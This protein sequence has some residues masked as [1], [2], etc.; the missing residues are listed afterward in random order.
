MSRKWLARRL[1]LESL[2][3][4]HRNVS[5]PLLVATVDG[6]EAV[7]D[8]HGLRRAG[9]DAEE[10]AVGEPAAEGALCQ[11]DLPEAASGRDR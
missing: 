5:C 2:H 11:H 3:Q 1:P 9:F 7:L 6:A 10:D 8:G 4:A